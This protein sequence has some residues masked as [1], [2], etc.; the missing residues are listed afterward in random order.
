MGAYSSA[1]ATTT[2]DQAI[3]NIVNS[4]CAIQNVSGITT[5]HG[6]IRQEGVSDCTV[7]VGN[8][9]SVDSKCAQ[10][11]TIDAASL[12]LASNKAEAV[13]AGVASASDTVSNTNIRKHI[14]AIL[15]QDC[16]AEITSQITDIYDGI[17]QKNSTHCH[18]DIVNKLDAKSTCQLGAA[19]KVMEKT[20]SKNFSKAVTKF[21][22]GMMVAFII[23][24]AIVV[25]GF[26]TVVYKGEARIAQ[27]AVSPWFWLGLTT[28]IVSIIGVSVLA[29]TIKKRYEEPAL[30]KI[31][32]HV[33][34]H[35]CVS[36]PNGYKR[37]MGDD[38]REKNTEC[39][40]R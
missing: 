21:S 22:L 26:F 9:A 3:T 6:G 40:K 16:G 13:S 32:E 25:I 27:V 34:S 28:L 33:N 7:T 24:G 4:K 17:V 38:P 35:K 30:C 5:V 8:I 20:D 11:A 18:I 37:E 12:T 15:N 14:T 39:I 2:L 23:L 19:I 10:K 31:N 29:F 1:H 36:C